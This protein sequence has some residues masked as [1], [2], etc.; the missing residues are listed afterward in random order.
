MVEGMIFLVLLLAQFAY[1]EINITTLS[2][3]LKRNGN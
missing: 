1:S 3:L 2:N